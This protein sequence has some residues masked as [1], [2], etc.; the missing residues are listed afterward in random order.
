MDYESELY[1][2]GIL[3]MKWGIRRYQPYPDGQKKGK[4]IGEAKLAKMN[5]KIA[6][7]NLKKAAFERTSKIPDVYDRAMSEISQAKKIIGKD[8]VERIMNKEIARDTTVTKAVL[9]TA[10]VARAAYLGTFV[11]G[12]LSGAI[13]RVTVSAMEGIINNPQVQQAAGAALKALAAN[14]NV[15]QLIRDAGLKWLSQTSGYS[16]AELLNSASYLND[17]IKAYNAALGD[18]YGYHV[19][20]IPGV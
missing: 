7:R 10:H 12:S 18:Q 20:T 9:T 15:E 16:E 13:T 8:Q 4:E 5:E 2:Y 1:H 6:K 17:G 19:P 14:P 11:L 3:G